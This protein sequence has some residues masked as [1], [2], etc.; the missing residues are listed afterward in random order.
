MTDRPQINGK[1]L[2]NLLR[3]MVDIYSPPGKE[4][5]I[6]DFL[7]SYLRRHGLPVARQ[8][9][10]EDRENLVV[11]PDD[12]EADLVFVGHLDT[13]EAYDLELYGYTQEG[14][15]AFGLGTADM[16]GG[17]AA[18]IEAFVT[19]W[20]AGYT[21]LPAALALVVGEE[22]SGDGAH[23]LVREFGFST[24][25]VGEPTN[26][27]PCMSHYGY[28]ETQLVTRGQRVHASLAPQASNAVTAMLHLLLEM[29]AYFDTR[30]TDAVYNIRDLTSARSGFAVPDSCEAWVDLH[31][32]PLANMGKITF[33]LEEVHDLFGEKYPDANSAIQFS[34]IHAGYELPVKGTLA[35]LLK[36][37]CKAHKI[38]FKPGAFPSHSDAN[39]LWAAGVKPVLLGPGRLEKAHTSDES[40]SL[41]QVAQAA[42]VYVDLAL[43]YGREE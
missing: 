6:V 5:D 29:T 33:A 26:M 24:A 7:Y 2:S 11:E 9:V 34:T 28:V 32:P 35:H 36:E 41:A 40:V 4:S 37:V 14:D 31:I 27:Q 17:C 22:D 23:R 12:G 10:D 1:R 30:M 13:V 42:Q 21:D 8:T 3:R 39:I 15:E 43:G 25:I 19:L 18:M 20:E 38:P 16:K